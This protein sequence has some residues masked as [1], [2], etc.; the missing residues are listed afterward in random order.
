M[1]EESDA[2]GVSRYA[3]FVADP[4]NPGTWSKE[5]AESLRALG[6][7]EREETLPLERAKAR[8]ITV[9]K[10]DGSRYVRAEHEGLVILAH[11]TKPT[12]N[13][14]RRVLLALRALYIRKPTQDL[15]T[16]AA[17]EIRKKLGK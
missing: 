4:D 7:T 12:P 8:L 6:G 11:E 13:L 14:E 10:A 16:K 9:D 5:Q 1:G 17:A 2:R 15:Y 3:F